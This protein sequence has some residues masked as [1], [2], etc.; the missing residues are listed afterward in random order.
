[1]AQTKGEKHPVLTL[2]GPHSGERNNLAFTLWPA[3]GWSPHLHHIHLVFAT[4]WQSAVRRPTNRDSD[5]ECHKLPPAHQCQ[6]AGIPA[7]VWDAFTPSLPL[8]V[9]AKADRGLQSGSTGSPQGWNQWGCPEGKLEEYVR[10]PGEGRKE[11]A[12]SSER[13]G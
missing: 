5:S 12:A 7:P 13:A 3:R 9:C 4:A 8:A 2:R 11:A 6:R 10:P 1:M